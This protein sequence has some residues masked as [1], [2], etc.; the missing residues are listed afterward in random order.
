MEI[1]QWLHE[2]KLTLDVDA[3][4]TEAIINDRLHILKWLYI[5]C[6]FNMDLC[7]KITKEHNNLSI[8]KWVTF[9]MIEKNES[10]NR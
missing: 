5:N 2:N 7:I 4:I 3:C 8:L 9:I 6:D 10:N 1:L